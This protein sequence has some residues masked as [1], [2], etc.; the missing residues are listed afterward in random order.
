ME[1]REI[2]IDSKTLY[3]GKVFDLKLDA[4][5]LPNGE[6]AMRET[7]NHPGAVCV[8]AMNSQ[9]EIAF[10]KQYRSACMKTLLEL[11][12]GKLER[13]EIP[14]NSAK[15]ELSEETGIIGK[16]FKSLGY[17][18]VTPGYSNEIIH[19]YACKV[20]SQ[21]K[22]NLDTDEFVES[23]FIKQ[24]KALDMVLNDE[25]H[26]AKTQICILKLSNLIS[27][28]KLELDS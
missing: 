11:P 16:E 17:I 9:K 28:G 26:D 2:I 14:L 24:E 25:I 10:V 8:A 15:R 19:L 12:A 5:K 4:V 21:G 23:I 1:L 20:E 13:G 3:K 6:T 18:Y 22:Q 7:V 27:S